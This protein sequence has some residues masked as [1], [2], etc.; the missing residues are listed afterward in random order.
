[1]P[2]RSGRLEKRIRL[3]VPVEISSIGDS[4][5]TE[6]TSTEN[7]SSLGVRVL[8]HVPKEVNERVIIRSLVGD[9]RTLARVTYCQW[10]P[11]GRFGVGIQFLGSATNW[12]EDSM[13]GAAV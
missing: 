2:V 4:S 8:L 1:M 7:V 13:V 6:R 12:S 9:L 3:A 5:P 11:D 10:L